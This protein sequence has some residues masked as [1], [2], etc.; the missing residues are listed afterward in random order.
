MQLITTFWSHGHYTFKNSVHKLIKF[1]AYFTFHF[2]DCKNL[3]TPGKNKNF[4]FP[5]I[6]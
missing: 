5:N 2:R 6:F 4:E 3:L 1:Q